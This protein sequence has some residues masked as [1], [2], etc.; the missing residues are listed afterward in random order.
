MLSKD[1]MGVGMASEFATRAGWP[2]TSAIT[3]AGTIATDATVALK[4]QRVILA[5][6][7]SNSGIRFPADAELMVPYIVSVVGGNTV[8]IYPPTGGTFNDAAVDTPIAIVDQLSGLF[9][10][11]S[12]TGWAAIGTVA[13]A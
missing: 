8:K 6:G 12:S 11:Y 13:P 3:G 9:Y 4:A 2:G 5:S 1:M 10:R 7:A